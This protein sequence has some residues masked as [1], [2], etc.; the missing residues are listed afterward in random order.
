MKQAAVLTGIVL[1]SSPSGDYDKRLV[2]LTRERGK[3]TAFARGARRP[4]SPMLAGTTPFSFGEFTVYE[5]STSYNLVQV[6][7]SNYFSE[8]SGSFSGPFYGFYFLEL[9]DYYTR[10]NNDEVFMLKLLY[11]T[12]R[13]LE[14]GNIEKEL[15]R[16]IFELKSLVIN[17]EYPELFQCTVCRGEPGESAAFSTENRGLVC[18]RCQKGIRCLPMNSSTIFT[19]QYII[20]SPIE[21][22]YTFT[23]SEK[24]LKELGNIMNRYM[25]SCVDRTFKSLD[26]LKECIKAE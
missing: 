19:M 4:N 6:N 1:S 13:A 15:I 21:K 5:G 2:I 24:V 9:T 14:K 20:T 11:Q 25:A 7:I 22:L 16:Y 26:V 10:E 18:G 23:V 3:I 12:L 17:G 8:L